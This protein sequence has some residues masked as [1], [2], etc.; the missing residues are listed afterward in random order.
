MHPWCH[1]SSQVPFRS[2][3]LSYLLLGDKTPST[4]A[5][6]SCGFACLS[7]FE[8]K[9][10]FQSE[11]ILMYISVLTASQPDWVLTLAQ[12][13]RPTPRITGPWSQEGSVG[14]SSDQPPDSAQ[15][16]PLHTAAS[17][18]HSPLVLSDSLG[19]PSFVHDWDHLQ[20]HSGKDEKNWI[21]YIPSPS[22]SWMLLIFH[23][24]TCSL[25]SWGGQNTH[26]P[27]SYL[28]PVYFFSY[29]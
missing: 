21:L 2:P 5:S 8:F 6:C 14:C 1:L 18:W 7:L 20:Q 12:S 23:K 11:M 10:S 29:S 25:C 17:E 26:P 13:P 28:H 19:F 27:T 9:L 15:L 16:T 22:S 24:A 4:P 3:A